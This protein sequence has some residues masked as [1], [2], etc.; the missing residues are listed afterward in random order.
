MPEKLV[1]KIK[2]TFKAIDKLVFFVFYFTSGFTHV[3]CVQI[4]VNL[5]NLC[6][7]R[8]DAI[9]FN[10]IYFETLKKITLYL[11]LVLRNY[12]VYLF[13]YLI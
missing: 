5:F 11:T 6:F 13:D 10:L 7:I 4:W 12:Q 9:F 2:I 3:D 1:K 8:P